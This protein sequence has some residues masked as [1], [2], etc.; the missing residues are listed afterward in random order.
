[1]DSKQLSIEKRI[2]KFMFEGSLEEL[3]YFLALF[4][5]SEKE[6]DFDNYLRQEILKML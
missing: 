1:M 5:K 6:F 2:I 3:D 4:R